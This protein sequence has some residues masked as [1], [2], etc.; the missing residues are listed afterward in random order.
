MKLFQHEDDARAYLIENVHSITH[1]ENRSK[2]KHIFSR[3]NLA[4]KDGPK[5]KVQFAV[6]FDALQG[7]Y[8]VQ[9]NEMPHK[10]AKISNKIPMQL[11]LACAKLRKADIPPRQ[12]LHSLQKK[13]GETTINRNQL[14]WLNRTYGV[15][16]TSRFTTMCEVVEYLERRK[17][18]ENDDEPFVLNMKHSK[19]S[20]DET[21]LQCVMSTSK[22]LKTAKRFRV[23]ACDATYKTN[24]DGYPL[25]ILGG[26]DANQKLH[27]I[28]YCISTRGK[29]ENYRFLFETVS[30]AIWRLYH[31]EFTPQ[32]IVADGP[33]A[34]AN[35][36]LEAFPNTPHENH[37][38]LFSREVRFRKTHSRR[39]RSGHFARHR[40]NAQFFVSQIIHISRK[41]VCGEMARH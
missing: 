22:L 25:M 8:L 11:R 5:C 36:F 41:N 9:S 24:M 4:R 38:V 37:H 13:F 30:S 18:F 33:I 6:R 15:H 39:K 28:A 7:T 40:W 26:S 20:A 14:Y 16:N 21:E 34:I 2:I 32:V 29:T 27:V 17:T 1:C 35:G 23:V 12:A 31:E 3:C 10:C 19:I